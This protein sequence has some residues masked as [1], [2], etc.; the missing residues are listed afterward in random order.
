[1]Q[2]VSLDYKVLGGR[3]HDFAANACS[4][5]I[6]TIAHSFRERVSV[7]PPHMHLLKRLELRSALLDGLDL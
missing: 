5:L 3:L 4:R 6:H 2:V 7:D 1:M